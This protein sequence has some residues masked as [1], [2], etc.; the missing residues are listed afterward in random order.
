MSRIAGILHWGHR[1]PDSAHREASGML[2]HMAAARPVL[3]V[4]ELG[5]FGAAGFGG[6]IHQ[7]DGGILVLDGRLLDRD[8]LDDG[9]PGGDAALL[10]RLCLRMGFERT[11]Q[12]VDGDI[13]VAFLETK[14]R[15]LWLARDRF[16]V[17]PLYYAR[18]PDGLAFASQP[19]PLAALPAVGAAVNRL[20]VALVAGSH[21]R[22]FDNAIEDSPFANVR[23]LPA[24]HLLEISPDRT[25][26]AEAYWR[27]EAKDLGTSDE[28]VLADRYEEL[29]L[30]AVQRRLDVA[31]NPAFTLSGGMDSSSI[32]C[33]AARL[34]GKPQA[35]FSSIYADPTYDERL[36]IKDVIEAGLAEWHPVELSDDIDLMA[37]VDRLVRIHNEPVA[38]ATWLSH[39]AVCRA[40]AQA[41]YGAL[42]GG[43]GGD[44]L[45]AGEYEY[46]PMFFA[47]LRA[48]GRS[49]QLEQ[50]IASW[51]QH[52][53]HPVH[54]KSPDIARS[55]MD[56]LTESGSAGHCRP[57]LE[58][59]NRYLAAIDPRWYDLS[60]F[61][62]VMEHPFGSFLANRA[63]QDLTRETTPCCLRAEDRQCEFHGLEHFD[64]FLDRA[65]VEFMFSVPSY[66]KIRNG[67]TKYLLRKATDNILP[68]TTRSRVK[69]TGWNAPAHVWF[70]GGRGLEALSDIVSSTAFRQRGLYNAMEVERLIAEHRRIICTG[71][72][73]ENHMMF[74]WQ[75]LNVECWLAWIDRSLPSALSTA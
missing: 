14:S 15:R 23:Q 65:M 51:A 71:E 8:R 26:K 37:T 69:K 35:A 21:Y 67:V 45:N 22:T 3:A 60:G 29:L 62:P 38:T 30:A 27:L 25:G 20:F 54:R 36:E 10:L 73:R 42:F 68:D 19:A 32:V 28:D 40:V 50:E 16:G 24:A 13:A 52:H 41:G 1:A 64:P 31:Q 39:D 2:A 34:K 57:N 66:M 49:E 63:Y 70:T 43:L 11:M 61:R 44:E 48:D 6:D 47:D 56:A 46:F 18:V 12:S 17:K 55:M 33:S 4:S 59:Q 5:V 9:G 72:T 7:Q 58:R 75:L 74:L 53:D